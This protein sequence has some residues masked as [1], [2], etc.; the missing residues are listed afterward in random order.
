ME[1]GGSSPVKLIRPDSSGRIA[2]TSANFPALKHFWDVNHISGAVL[3]DTVGTQHVT[4]DAGR[5]LVDSEGFAK[6]GAA[7]GNYCPADFEAPG[8]RDF[9]VGRAKAT[10]RRRGLNRRGK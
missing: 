9:S 2:P 7:G 10:R 4:T 8:N 3:L 1:F 5:W 6:W